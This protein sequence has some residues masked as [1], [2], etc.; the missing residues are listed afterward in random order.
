MKRITIFKTLVAAAIAAFG[1][2]GVAH[3]QVTVPN[4]WTV[5]TGSSTIA[6]RNASLTIPCAN[7]AGG[8]GGGGISPTSTNT[9]TVPQSFN[10]ISNTGNVTSTSIT[11]QSLNANVAGSAA[12]QSII[13]GELDLAA[14]TIIF[15]NNTSTGDYGAYMNQLCNTAG[16][17]GATSILIKVPGESVTFSTPIVDVYKCTYEGI[18]NNGT[19]WNWGGAQGTTAFTLNSSSSFSATRAGGGITGIHLEIPG[20]SESLTNPTVAIQTGGN[21]GGGAFTPF[22]LNNIIGGFGIAMDF[23]TNTVNEQVISNVATFNGAA[24]RVEPSTGNS[25][26][27]VLIAFNWLTDCRGSTTTVDGVVSGA[28]QGIWFKNGSVEN[29]FMTDNDTDNCQVYEDD[30]NNVWVSGDEMENSQSVGDGA[31]TPFY[32]T[33]GHSNFTLNGLQIMNDAT[34]TANTYPAVFHIGS[35]ATISGVTVNKNGGNGAV[36]I[37]YLLDNDGNGGN[38]KVQISDIVNNSGFNAFGNFSSSGFSTSS[39]NGSIFQTAN[40]P[41]S[42]YYVPTSTGQYMLVNVAGVVTSTTGNWSG[43]WQGVNSSSF[44]LSSNPSGYGTSNVSTSSA[45]TWSAPQTFTKVGIATGTLTTTGC[46]NGVVTGSNNA[47]KIAIGSSTVNCTLNFS[48][49]WTNPP[50]CVLT[51][52]TSSANIIRAQTITTTTDLFSD[53]SNLPTSSVVDYICMGIP[54]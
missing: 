18:G 37:P 13:N 21:G 24:L 41:L 44:Y 54:N 5:N 46:G 50:V 19:I 53:T 43:T 17:A 49:A 9:F 33:G 30:N 26:E 12:V 8:C 20:G 14:G 36:A 11:T 32:I 52:A 51:N 48:P 7:I 45:N 40:N 27:G 28:N 23:S 42:G 1:L 29:A 25:G 4:Y 15:A 35:N 47:G 6:P 10:G 2:F 38:E 22:I 16:A 34:S 31:F 3:A 39:F